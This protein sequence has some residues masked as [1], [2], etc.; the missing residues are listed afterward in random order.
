VHLVT[1]ILAVRGGLTAAEIMGRLR[2]DALW[3]GFYAVF[4]LCAGLHGAIGLRNIAGET[5][6]WRAGAAERRRDGLRR[7][8]RREELR[9]AC[10]DLLGHADARAVAGELSDLAEATL[11]AL[12]EALRDASE[13][14][15]E[16]ASQAASEV[17]FPFAVIGMGKLGGAELSYASDL[18]VLFVHDGPSEGAER[19]AETI[20][21]DIGSQTT[22]GRAW[23]I[24]AR[25]RPEGR[26]GALALRLDGYRSYWA[27]RA[28]LWERQAL[29][30]AR[31]VAGDPDLAARFEQARLEMVYRRPLDEDEAR[32]IRRLKARV[33]TERIRP[34]DDP[35]FHLKL[36]PGALADVEWT[37]QLLQLRAGADDPSVRTASTLAGLEALVAGGYLDATDG[38]L[39]AAS[40]RFCERARNARY[41]HVGARADALPG[42]PQEAAHLVGCWASTSS[43]RPRC[44]RRTVR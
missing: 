20:I 10:R 41:L 17:G 24:D 35:A 7:F 14:A 6:G 5:L 37:V 13:T 29:V 34:P 1:I 21:R 39:L 32:E 31:P 15:P 36:G 26:A 42:R 25:L 8:V 44:G 18:D 9:I 19:L 11:E 23:E 30:R 22:E 33:E 27:E 16:T 4:A 38:E 40:Y 43:R 12:L 28:R 3:L 2:G